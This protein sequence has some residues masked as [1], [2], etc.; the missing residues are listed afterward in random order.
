M[1][2]TVTYKS[3][4][5]KDI[6]ITAKIKCLWYQEN[7]SLESRKQT[8]IILVIIFR[9][10]VNNTDSQVPWKSY[11]INHNNIDKI[12]TV[13]SA[14]IEITHSVMNQQTYVNKY[15]EYVLKCFGTHAVE[16]EVITDWQLMS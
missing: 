16:S 9:R 11:V 6:F 4:S 8:Q 3:F 1:V 7:A 5:V 14:N 13:S 10:V 12:F 2:S 15:P